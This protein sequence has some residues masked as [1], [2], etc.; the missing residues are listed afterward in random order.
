MSPTKPTCE[1]AHLTTGPHENAG[2]FVPPTPEVVEA[3]SKLLGGRIPV[4]FL[5]FLGAAA[6]LIRL[7]AVLAMRDINTGPEGAPSNDDVSFNNLAVHVARGEGYVGDSGKPT[8]FRAP[9]FPFYLAGIYLVTAGPHYPLAYLT[10]CFLGSL[11]CILTYFLA[12][13]LVSERAAR[14]A[15]ILHAVYLGH[16]YFATVFVSE[17]LYI[18]LQTLGVW[19]FVRRMT[20]PVPLRMKVLVGSATSSSASRWRSMR[21]VRQSFAISTT[22]RDR[23]PLNCSSLVSKRV[24]RAKASAVAPAN[25]AM[26]FPL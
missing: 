24:N 1:A 23:L 18:P 25:P 20:S 8:S 5:V 12:R 26:I 11:S 13:E 9:G 15:A 14:T 7:C 6:F 22:E 3:K 21:S 2:S 19:L 4:R 16:I 10:F 17:N